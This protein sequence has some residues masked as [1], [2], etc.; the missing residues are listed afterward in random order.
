MGYTNFPHGITSFGVP[1]YGV[2]GDVVAG[3]V[4]WVGS[5]KGDSWNAGVDTDGG[6]TKDNP[7]KTIDYAIGKCTANNGDV[8]YVLPQHAETISAAAGI[9]ADVACISIIGLGNGTIRPIITFSATASTFTVTAANVAIE[10]MQFQNAIDSLVSGISI[11]AA[12]CSIK[13]CEFS[14]PTSTNDALIWILTTAAADDLTIQGNIFRAS[15]AGPTEAI[16]LVGTDR[17]NIL[18]NYLIG[19]WSTAAIN[20][21]TTACLEILIARNTISNSVT[22]KLAIDLVAACTGRI[23]YNS[24][25]VV[26]TAGISD[27]AIIDAANCQLAQNYFSDAAGETGKLIGTVSA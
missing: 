3:N 11:T 1:I 8:I 5:V 16:R 19:S 13:G 25:T 2:A 22:D 12:G 26:S 10:N 18:D 27:A 21:I 23:E 4:W 15:H 17:A 7:F 20:A 9:A 6:G 14:Q 24:G